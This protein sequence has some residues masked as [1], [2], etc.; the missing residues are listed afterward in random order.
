MLHL[1]QAQHAIAKKTCV[2]VSPLTLRSFRASGTHRTRSNRALVGPLELRVRELAGHAAL[3][4]GRERLVH[5]REGHRGLE[6]RVLRDRRL[7]DPLLFAVH[8]LCCFQR[9]LN[10][11]LVR[12]KL[13]ATGRVLQHRDGAA[14][15]EEEE[16]A[17]QVPRQETAR[18]LNSRGSDA[19]RGGASARGAGACRASRASRRTPRTGPWS[20]HLP[21][22]AWRPGASQRGR[23]ASFLSRSSSFVFFFFSGLSLSLTFFLSFTTTTLFRERCYYSSRCSTTPRVSSLVLIIRT[24]LKSSFVFSL[25]FFL[26]IFSYVKARS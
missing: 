4:Q 8:L 11:P 24:V 9:R 26:V 18:N 2:F 3:L 10:E 12:P 13:L 6:L 19:R 7:R 1:G 16:E 25:F 5:L 14:V 21:A 22:A 23:G 20:S 15:E 17:E